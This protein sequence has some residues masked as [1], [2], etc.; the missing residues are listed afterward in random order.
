M[1]VSSDFIHD[2]Y[3]QVS[4]EKMVNCVAGMTSTTKGYGFGG[5]RSSRFSEDKKAGGDWGSS[6]A[7]VSQTISMSSAGSPPTLRS[8]SS[9]SSSRQQQQHPAKS[10]VS[11]A[12]L[13]GS[14]RDPDDLVGPAERARSNPMAS[15]WVAS[16]SAQDRPRPYTSGE[17]TRRRT[18]SN[19]ARWGNGGKR[20][21]GVGWRSWVNREGLDG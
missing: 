19:G 15:Q 13:Y 12:Q 9:A 17:L 21:N 3:A 5:Q 20:G 10:P 18:I 1:P 4:P 7:G 6:S 8:L 16:L 2:K 14:E 11:A